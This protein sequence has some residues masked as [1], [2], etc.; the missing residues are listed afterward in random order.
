MSPRI[1]FPW[2]FLF[3]AAP[4]LASA[5]CGIPFRDAESLQANTCQS[6]SD[7]GPGAL[8][9][10]AGE[11]SLC[12]AGKAE[13]SG[14][15]LEV[16]PPAQAANATTQ[17]FLIAAE[18]QGLVLQNITSGNVHFSP[19]LPS[20][21]R[22]SKGIIQ[23]IADKASIAAKIEFA[24]VAPF[25]GLNTKPASADAIK[26]GGGTDYTF[27]TE[28]P[29]GT[30]D[31]YVEP[32]ESVTCGG[33]PLPPVFIPEKE[34]ATDTTFQLELEPARHLIGQITTSPGMSL[35]GWT[36][37][38]IDQ[39]K[40][41]RISDIQILDQ[42]SPTLPAAISVH[43]NL[44]SS[45][46]LKPVL[47]LSPPPDVPLP[48]VF[49][50][51]AAIDLLGQN[52]VDLQ[53]SQLVLE[54]RQVAGH[55]FG[56]NAQAIISTLTFQS[57]VLSGFENAAYTITKDT[58]AGGV[59]Q[60]IGLPPGTYRVMA[61]PIDDETKAIR[62][63][64]WK[65]E[66]D[67]LNCFC[68]QVVTLNDKITLQGSVSTPSQGLIQEADIVISPSLPTPPS[69]LDRE[70]GRMPFLPREAIGYVS[71]GAF[72]V[73]L[74]PG[75]IDFYVRPKPNSGYPWLVRHRL[76]V[77][78]D[79]EGNISSLGPISIP[80]PLVVSGTIADAENLGIEGATVRA[81][82]P[83]PDETGTTS[84]AI[85]IAETLTGE[86]GQYVLLLPPSISP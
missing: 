7:C 42:P 9:V 57:T 67:P 27:E 65:I 15:L 79:A 73:P 44:I 74:D 38:V 80:H 53:L 12:A 66:N 39:D 4:A 6:A 28:F 43:Y 16:R 51:L 54:Q 10:P 72:A 29:P 40:G 22:I 75:E 37:Q 46:K 76:D 1:V 31:I 64:E 59:F 52:K 45:L 8:C 61:Q 58:S 56:Q 23:C 2:P 69:Y 63:V 33:L 14:L 77:Q 48:T 25:A 36:L 21:V 71:G 11:I 86:G 32:A 30:Y 20:P 5:A 82:L 34:I 85:Q 24:R 18:Q 62:E 83:V 17:S 47:R 35:T 55:V 3:A 78:A 19:V 50:D 70:L 49:W 60:D 81:W 41:R 68:G 84:T 13:L 26:N